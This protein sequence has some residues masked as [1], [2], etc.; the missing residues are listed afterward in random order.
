MS[1]DDVI[2]TIGGS[3]IIN[4]IEDLK[5]G[6]KYVSNIEKE[7]YSEGNSCVEHNSY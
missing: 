4:N 7:W 3:I 2:D 6:C 5:G 1:T